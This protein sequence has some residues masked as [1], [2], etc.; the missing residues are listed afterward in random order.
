MTILITGGTALV[1]RNIHELLRKKYDIF[2]PTHQ[3]LDLCD[4]MAV[5]R[6]IRQHTITAVIHGAMQGGDAVV[7]HAVQ[8]FLNLTQQIDRFDTFIYFGSGAEFGKHRDLHKVTEAEFGRILPRDRYGLAKFTLQRLAE[9]MNTVVNLRLFGVYGKYEPYW[10]KFI[11]QTILYYLLDIPIY[12]KQNVVFDYVYIDD[13]VSVVDYFLQHPP[14]HNSYNVTT[15]HSI[16]LLEI[17]DIIFEIGRKRVPIHVEREGLNYEYTGN[18]SRLISEVP[19]QFHSYRE[20]ISKLYGYY[21]DHLKDI[22]RSKLT[23]ATYMQSLT[24]K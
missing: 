1:G 15:N 21:K 23:D 7:Q 13:V 20:G 16:S 5:D 19:I 24:A 10:C 18:N 3:E 6:Y 9:G 22:D 4:F 8:M 2:A 11:S 14:K 17:I 12:I